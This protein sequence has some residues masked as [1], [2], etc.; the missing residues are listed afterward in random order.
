MLEHN[1]PSPPVTSLRRRIVEIV[2]AYV[3]HTA[4]VGHPFRPVP[5][6]QEWARRVNETWRTG[7]LRCLQTFTF[8]RE[9][10]DREKAPPLPKNQLGFLQFATC[11]DDT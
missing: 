6:H 10:F 8:L 2:L 9:M 1:L 4:D 7:G 3:V 5:Q 11:H